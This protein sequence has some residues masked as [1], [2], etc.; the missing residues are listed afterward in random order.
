MDQEKLYLLIMATNLEMK[1]CSA[2]A[3]LT[4][5]QGSPIQCSYGQ[6]FLKRDGLNSQVSGQSKVH[7]ISSSPRINEGKKLVMLVT[8]IQ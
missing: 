4:R 7:K 3:Y 8:P 6:G 1:G 2:L 5:S